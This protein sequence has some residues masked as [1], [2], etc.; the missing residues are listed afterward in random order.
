MLSCEIESPLML[1]LGFGLG[2]GFELGFG[3]DLGQQLVTFLLV[4]KT[5]IYS[6]LSQP[7]EKRY[8]RYSL[9]LSGN[10][11]ADPSLLL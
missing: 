1:E 11:R 9:L 7:R 8:C 6:I 3:P 5:F 2:L 10:V 4:L